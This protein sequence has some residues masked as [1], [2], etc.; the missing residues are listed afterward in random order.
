M[1]NTAPG[2]DGNDPD[3]TLMRF[4]VLVSYSMSRVAFSGLHPFV[5]GRP[6]RGA[7]DVLPFARVR[8]GGADPLGRRGRGRG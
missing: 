6:E 1:N 4:C 3:S 2:V 8:P 5:C 7:A